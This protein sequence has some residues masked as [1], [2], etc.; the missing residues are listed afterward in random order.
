[1]QLSGIGWAVL[2]LAALAVIALFSRKLIYWHSTWQHSVNEVLAGHGHAAG[3]EGGADREA[4]SHRLETWDMQL[5]DCTVPV[6]APYAGASLAA[7]QIPARFGCFVVE[8]ERNHLAIAQPSSDFTC[9][10]GDKLLLL[11][12]PRE[13]EKACAFLEGEAEAGEHRADFDRAVLESF[14]VPAQGPT[15]QPLG[16]L[17]IARRTGVRVLGIARDEAKILVPQATEVLRPGDRILG[18]GTLDQLR[19]FRSWLAAKPQRA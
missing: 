6:G 13:I 9:F 11:G 16:E 12:R 2:G 4:L 8:V 7:L 10:P 17:Q 14:V 15:G 18:L 1:V 3:P 19:G 5:H